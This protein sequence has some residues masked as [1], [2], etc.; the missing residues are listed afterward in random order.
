MFWLNK[1]LKPPIRIKRYHEGG[2]QL[3]LLSPALSF[4]LCAHSHQRGVWRH[5]ILLPQHVATTA[6]DFSQEELAFQELCAKQQI[7]TRQ[8]AGFN[9]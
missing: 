4:V 5:M 1:N 2:Y 6:A 8:E 3:D 9:L 7:M